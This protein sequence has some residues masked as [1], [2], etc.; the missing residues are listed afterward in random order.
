MPA[1]EVYSQFEVLR[2]E[3]YEL[4]NLYGLDSAIVLSKSQELDQLHNLINQ[5]KKPNA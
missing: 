5:T 3:M 2:L 1:Q 4:S